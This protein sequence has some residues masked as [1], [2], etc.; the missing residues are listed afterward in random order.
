MTHQP[1]HDP[2]RDFSAPKPQAPQQPPQPHP[3]QPQQPVQPH[4]Q[5]Q[6]PMPG[7]PM[8][9]YPQQPTMPPG[10]QPP[11]QPTGPWQEFKQPGVVSGAVKDG[12]KSW[13]KGKMLGYGIM[14]LIVVLVAGPVFLWS[15]L[16]GGGGGGG[17]ASSDTGNDRP[18][19]GSTSGS[20]RPPAGSTSGSDDEPGSSSGGAGSSDDTLT[21]TLPDD[22]QTYSEE[23]NSDG[24]MSYQYR[25]GDLWTLVIAEFHADAPESLAEECKRMTNDSGARDIV[26]PESI[27]RS[28]DAEA[29]RCQ[30]TEKDPAMNDDAVYTYYLAKKK[31][32]STYVEIRLSSPTEDNDLGISAAEVSNARKQGK[33]MIRDAL[34]GWGVEITS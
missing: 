24:L 9:P 6:P 13:A 32:D 10:G 27:A 12:F 21:F 25:Q 5:Q 19:A 4:P 3:Q 34:A 16:T 18:P 1:P 30:S 11:Q 22:W 7:Q 8:Q 29:V 14:A 26:E 2:Y 28:D 33:T 23:R 20:D 17:T 31:G 15:M